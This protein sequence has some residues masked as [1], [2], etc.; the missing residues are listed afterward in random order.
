MFYPCLNMYRAPCYMY[1]YTKFWPGRA[2]N[3]AARRLAVILENKLSAITPVES[4]PND[5]IISKF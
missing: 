5:W 1:I 3:M 4:W 2:L